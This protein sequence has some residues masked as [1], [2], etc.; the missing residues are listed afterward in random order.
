MQTDHALIQACRKGDRKAQMRLYDQCYGLMMSICIRY[1]R[2]RQEAGAR[3]NLAF[4]KVL[5][6]LDQVDPAGNFKAWVG[7]VTLR[8]LI[9]EF[10]QQ[11]RHYSNTVYNGHEIHDEAW[12]SE[13]GSGRTPDVIDP[14]KVMLLINRLPE[15]TREVFNLFAIDGYAHKEIASMLAISEN[16]SKWHVHDA[17]RRLREALAPQAKTKSMS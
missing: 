1:C 4:L 15:M 5:Q 16:T 6:H 12:M 14:E 2:D 7:Q 11:R 8:T 10:R 9:D 13:S 3:L 17:R